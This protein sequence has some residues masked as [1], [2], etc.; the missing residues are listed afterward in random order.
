MV[1]SV[2]RA[3][4]RVC[5][6]ATISQLWNISCN[7][8]F[9]KRARLSNL[10][11][12]ELRK[13]H[14]ASAFLRVLINFDFVSTLRAEMCSVVIGIASIFEGIHAVAVCRDRRKTCPTGLVED[15]WF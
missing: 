2:Y 3:S 8:D 12:F 15:E 9:D 13:I 7:S 11:V 6:S 10:V 1:N 4:E 5:E 14:L